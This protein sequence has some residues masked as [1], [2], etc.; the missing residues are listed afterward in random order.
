MAI[1]VLIAMGNISEIDVNKLSSTIFIGEL[2]LDGKINRT[3]GVLPMCI[4][5]KELGIKTVILPKENANEASIISKL[6]IIPVTNIEEVIQYLNK[7]KDIPKHIKK[8][9]IFNKNYNID[10]SEVKGQENIKRALE[11]TAAG[12]H[13]CLM[14]GSPRFR[15]DDDGKKINYDFA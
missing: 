7:K 11:I 8:E 12:G 4:E 10:F 15:K 13:N 1:G 3:N 5:A 2:S 9:N 6:D 14:L